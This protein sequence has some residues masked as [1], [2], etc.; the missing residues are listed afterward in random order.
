MEKQ[1]KG[2]KG[3]ERNNRIGGGNIFEELT[4]GSG[5]IN[6]GEDIDKIELEEVTLNIQAESSIRNESKPVL[7]KIR[8]TGRISK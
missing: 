7:Q 3:K 2:T 5:K 1:R 4:E 6:V 8:S